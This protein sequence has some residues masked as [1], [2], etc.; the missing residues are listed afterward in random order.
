MMRTS[1]SVHGLVFVGFLPAND[2][3]GML[4]ATEEMLLV[5]GEFVRRYE[6]R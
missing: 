1:E 3:Q 5:G 2:P 6:N 4:P